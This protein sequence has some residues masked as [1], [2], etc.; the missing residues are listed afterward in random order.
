[1]MFVP[2]IV[3]APPSATVPVLPAALFTVRLF[4]PR[5][6]AGAI[7]PAMVRVWPAAAS[8][9]AVLVAV[10]KGETAP[11]P[12]PRLVARVTF[13]VASKSPPASTTLLA[14]AVAGTSP[15]LPGPPGDVPSAA[16]LTTPPMVVPPV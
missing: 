6:P 8:S 7:A 11:M 9:S 14:W 3:F 12:T 1:M 13:A 10:F 4:T 5:L 2:L 16:M 15:R